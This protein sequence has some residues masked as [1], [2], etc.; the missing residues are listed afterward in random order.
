[1]KILWKRGEIAPKEQFLLFFTI[2]CCLMIDRCVKTGTR[3][4]LRDKR[5]FEISEFEIT[6][7]DCISNMVRLSTAAIYSCLFVTLGET[8]F[9][10][11][12]QLKSAG[13]SHIFSLKPCCGYSSEASHQSASYVYP[14]HSFLWRNKKSILW[15][16]LSPGAMNGI[17][18]CFCLI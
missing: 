12:F 6:R 17:H 11:I 18:D 7:V 9:R 2:F 16:P 15:V 14:Q 4:S 1:M 8:Q 13:I 3:F 10:H 5:L